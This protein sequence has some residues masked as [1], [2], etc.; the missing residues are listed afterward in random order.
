MST[1]TTTPPALWFTA[2]DRA[3]MANGGPLPVDPTS[4]AIREAAKWSAYQRDQL[5]A[6]LDSQIVDLERNLAIAQDQNHRLIARGFR[7]HGRGWSAAADLLIAAS[8]GASPEVVGFA[9][10]IAGEM[11]GN[12]SVAEAAAIISDPA[13]PVTDGGSQ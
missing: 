7:E 8:C 11:R 9:L 3:A 4:S 6:E 5:K 10:R 13:V 1:D 12:A 2:A